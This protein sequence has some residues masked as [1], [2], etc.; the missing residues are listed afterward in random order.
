MSNPD[1]TSAIGAL[2][3]EATIA[4]LQAAMDSGAISAEALTMA[5]LERIEAL[6]RAG[7]C[8]NA[9]I[10]I[11]PSALKT[12]IALDTERNA[13]GPRSPLHGIPILLKDNIDTLDD[14]ATTAGSLALLGSRPAAEATVTSRLRAAGA[15]ILGKANMSEWA[16][17]RST[18]SSS[19]WSAR[20][21]Q[22]RNPYV[23]SRSPC[24]SSSGSA[25]AV[26]AS[27]CVVAIGTETDGSIS[28][29]SAL[30]GVVGIKPT[31]GLTSRAGVVPI[32]FTQDTVGPHARCVADAATVLGIIAG[33]DPRD[34][35]TAAAAGHAR[36]DY[37]TC[38]QADAL[39][40][41]R[42]GVLRSDRFAGFGRHVEQA[43][44]NAL[45]AM[46]DA[47]AHIVDP[48]TLPDDLLAFGEAELTVL[49]YE[50]KD[51][52]NRYLASRVPDPQA[53]DP[54]PHS[55][56]ELIVFNE[57]HA[58]HE[59]RFFGQE[60]LL[61]AAAVG[62]LN[63]PAY[64]QA[65]VA[66]RDTVRQ[67]LDTVLYEKQLDALVAPATGLAWP[68]DL[69]AGDRYPGGS[70]SLAARAGYPMVTVPAG[71]AFGLPIAI[72]FIG[73][74]WSEPMLIRLAYAF[75]Q[76]TRWRRPPTYRLWLEGD[77][78]LPTVTA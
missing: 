33:P 36:P 32:S 9:V 73:G 66:S 25:I 2:A 15:V 27:M 8:L 26:A 65:L 46:I 14:T 75:E 67:A 39:R 45:T 21:G 74:A 49:I 60:L 51:T 29:P 71:M 78:E 16:N 7:P 57:R 63:D 77:N 41:A 44:A 11:S 34:P 58:E 55:L 17:F 38:L 6:N 70:S 13:H 56:A 5:C 22:A 54:P 19:G 52:L 3:Y 43:F 24:G 30:C 20:G 48:V 31:V 69:I 76:A 23:L 1:P 53:T 28:C 42:I 47:G 64:Q 68:I 62:D 4:Q 10:E 61:Q 59:L 37:R 18:A 40:G 50:F 12:A 35:A 72:N